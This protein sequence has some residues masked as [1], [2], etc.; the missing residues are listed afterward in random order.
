MNNLLSF[1]PFRHQKLLFD[2][3]L[4]HIPSKHKTLP[5]NYPTKYAII[6]GNTKRKGFRK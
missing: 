3:G 4:Y 5:I 6:R 2:C 1:R